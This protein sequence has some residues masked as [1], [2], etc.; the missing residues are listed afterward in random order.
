MPKKLAI[1]SKTLVLFSTNQK[2][3]QS[4]TNRRH[5]NTY[6]H[7]LVSYTQILNIKQG[8]RALLDSGACENV[9]LLADSLPPSIYPE[10]SQNFRLEETNWRLEGGKNYHTDEELHQ[11]TTTT[12]DTLYYTRIGHLRGQ[13][14]SYTITSQSVILQRANQLY[15]N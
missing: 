8:D 3:D 12:T 4:A 11:P 10:V 9:P 2:P 13:P 14:I 7:E 1:T 5:E 15:Y 6:T